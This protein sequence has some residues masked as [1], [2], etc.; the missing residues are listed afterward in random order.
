MVRT[1]CAGLPYAAF[2]KLGVIRNT[3]AFISVYNRLVEIQ[4]QVARCLAP[5][6]NLHLVNRMDILRQSLDG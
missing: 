3:I 6:Q 4:N 5:P 1:H 2:S